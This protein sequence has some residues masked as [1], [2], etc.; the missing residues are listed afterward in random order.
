MK[1][2]EL[3]WTCSEHG[4]MINEYKVLIRNPKGKRPLGRPKCR[5]DD[6]IMDLRNTGLEGMDWIYP[7]KDRTL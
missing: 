7:A 6:N 5:W 3:G 1:E 2:D 4:K